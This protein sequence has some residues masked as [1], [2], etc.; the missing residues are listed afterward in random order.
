MDLI[1]SVIISGVYARFWRDRRTRSTLYH[2]E[3]KYS[4][5]FIG[6]KNEEMLK[7]P[8]FKGDTPG[9]HLPFQRKTGRQVR[10]T[11]SV[12]QMYEVQHGMNLAVLES[13]AVC[14][15]TSR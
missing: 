5:V 11:G 10:A 15:Q 3:M 8:S 4:S 7:R 9:Y 6:T 12:I 14:K 13:N 1:V 2:G